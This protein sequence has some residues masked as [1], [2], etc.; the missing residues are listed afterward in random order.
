MA[1]MGKKLV[2]PL[3]AFLMLTVLSSYTCIFGKK[4]GIKGMI[5]LVKGN[6]MPSPD[7]MLPPKKPLQTTLYIYELTNIDQVTRA[8]AHAPFYTAINTK[9]I[10][11]VNSDTK[12]EFKVKLPPG[13]YSLFIKKDDRFYANLFDEKNNI[14]PVTVAKG[15]FTEVEVRADYDAVY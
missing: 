1:M 6:Q 9:L 7:Q 5:Y 4:G 11:Q 12:G 10:K 2:L 15:K 13:Q 3:L 14:A 8:E